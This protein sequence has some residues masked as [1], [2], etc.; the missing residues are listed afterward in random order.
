MWSL[1]ARP[2]VRRSIAGA[3]AALAINLVE[4]CVARLG[5]AEAVFTDEAG[6]GVG[7]EQLQEEV[8]EATHRF[9]PYRC[10]DY[11]ARNRADALF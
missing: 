8:G 11:V 6:D 3:A 5:D 10:L 7:I 2:L 1:A 9:G 4:D